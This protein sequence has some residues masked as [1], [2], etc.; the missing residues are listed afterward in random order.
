ME[1]NQI[2]TDFFLCIGDAYDSNSTVLLNGACGGYT[3][4]EYGVF[5]ILESGTLLASFA[6]DQTQR[7]EEPDFQSWDGS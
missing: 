4:R 5:E 1:I 3:G 6:G 7:Q 2:E